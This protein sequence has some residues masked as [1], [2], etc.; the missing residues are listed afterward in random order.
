MNHVI[1][2]G[3]ITKDLQLKQSTRGKNYVSFQIA[4]KRNYRNEQGD[5]DSD[6]F[7]CKAWGKLAE[8]LVNTQ[9]SGS[10]IG[11]H[12]R[13]ESRSY[14]EQG[15][16][17]YITEIVA[18]EIQYLEPKN[19]RSNSNQPQNQSNNNGQFNN[20]PNYQGNNGGQPSFGSGG[21]YNPP[22]QFGGQPPFPPNG[23]GGFPP[24]GSY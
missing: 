15:K 7:M 20:Q 16:T 11:I 17:V 22:S 3:R 14:Q 21:G 12:G 8:N 23:Q 1:E 10:L 9:G 4:V 18:D 13:L 2:V 19:T 5:Y 6:F 24:H